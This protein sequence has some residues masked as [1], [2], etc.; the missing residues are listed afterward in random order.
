MAEW[1]YVKMLRSTLS[2]SRNEISRAGL[3]RVGNV[4]FLEHD[5]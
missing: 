3:A 2:V 5:W 1:N 4:S